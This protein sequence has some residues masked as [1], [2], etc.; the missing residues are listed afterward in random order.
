MIDNTQN[1]IDVRD[2]IDRFE[3]LEELRDE[4]GD[5]PNDLDIVTEYNELACILEE[6][7]GNGGDE[8]WRGDWYPLTL[9]RDSYFELAMDEL[10]ADCYTIP[11][12][13]PFMTVT[14][15]YV[16]LQMD[17]TSIEIDGVTYWYR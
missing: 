8:Q 2:L 6:L 13:P 16:A 12:L 11:E 15:D 9:I 4:N 5:F 7:Q 3:E 1:I 10:V 17:Y 14:L